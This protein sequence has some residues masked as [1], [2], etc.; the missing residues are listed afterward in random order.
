[1]TISGLSAGAANLDLPSVIGH[2]G[3]AAHAPENTLVGFRVARELGCD[4]VEFDVR[5]TADGALVVCH[6]D[7]LDRTTAGRGR[8]SKLPLAM[9]REL[10]AGGW[11]GAKFAG[12][13]V[14]T[15]EEA[16]VCC[17]E[18]GLGANVEIKAERDRGP[19]TTDAVATC[20]E[21]HTGPLPPVL[22]SSFLL[23]AVAE[24]ALRMPAVPRGM[25]WRKIPHNWR[26]IA[27]Q[28]GCATI[29]CGHADL[30]ERVA[31]EIG[32]AGYPLL[33]YTVN[34]VVRAR[35]LAEWGVA[36]VF[37]DAPDIIL[38]ALAENTAGARRGA[39]L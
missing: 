31:A 21:R 33:A 38:A 12:E 2:R 14:P 32:A 3:A 39:R 23:D 22:I 27:E 35:Q 30:T 4:W 37:A 8:I 16:L 15:L 1:M 25:L 13:R 17:R 26:T 9:I 10:D 19:A 34:D 6:D 7:R 24:A 28:L 36:S 29:H 5:L 18:L 20:L 11:F